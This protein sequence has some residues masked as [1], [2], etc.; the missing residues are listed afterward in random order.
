[1]T[2]ISLM[3]LSNFASFPIDIRNKYLCSSRMPTE[4]I[5]DIQE[6]INELEKN[7]DDSRKVQKKAQKTLDGLKKKADSETT[8]KGKKKS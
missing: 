8:N 6:L 5:K 2:S 1:M 7:L 4:R 3:P